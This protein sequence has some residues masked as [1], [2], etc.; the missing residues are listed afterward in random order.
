M[1]LAVAVRLVS[2]MLTADHDRF[3]S[4]LAQQALLARHVQFDPDV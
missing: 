2:V 4:G 1:Y 3:V